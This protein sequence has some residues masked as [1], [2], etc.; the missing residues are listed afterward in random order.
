MRVSFWNSVHLSYPVLYLSVVCCAYTDVPSQNKL[1]GQRQISL[2]SYQKRIL[3]DTR[4]STK[5][6]IKTTAMWSK[7]LHIS[8]SAHL[9]GFHAR[10]KQRCDAGHTIKCYYNYKSAT[11]FPLLLASNSRGTSSVVM[12]YLK[13][14]RG[15]F[16]SC[17]RQI[18]TSI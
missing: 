1:N 2:H 18:T 7:I 13:K 14:Q 16:S 5:Q 17:L 6:L 3:C 11:Y 15:F 8:P 4:T 10:T 9:G 12:L